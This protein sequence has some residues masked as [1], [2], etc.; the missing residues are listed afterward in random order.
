MSNE[1]VF[2]KT[3]AQVASESIE[4]PAA[5]AVDNS[6]NVPEGRK[7]LDE[8]TVSDV[9]WVNIPNAESVGESTPEI[10]ISCYFSQP[11]RTVQG[12]DGPFYT[13]MTAKDG[14]ELDEF[15]VEGISEGD[16]VNM[17]LPNW[18]LIYKMDKLRR[19]CK[20]NNFTLNGQTISLARVAEGRKTAG[21]NFE[22]IVSSLSKKIVGTA[23]GKGSEVVN[24]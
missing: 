23:D 22:M 13:G 1:N 5:K 21:R 2:E 3:E 4:T 20:E 14:T 18:E 24:L 17:R 15:I 6:E 7:V 12:K 10:K 19:Y 11:G 16:K 9:K 8:T